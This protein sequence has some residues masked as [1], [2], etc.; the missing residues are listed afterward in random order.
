MDKDI[1]KEMDVVADITGGIEFGKP[2]R[3][4]FYKK[5]IS[6]IDYT[7][8]PSKYVGVDSRGNKGIYAIEHIVRAKPCR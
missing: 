1:E 6:I 7:R 5:Q 8:L 2:Y 3:F 4:W